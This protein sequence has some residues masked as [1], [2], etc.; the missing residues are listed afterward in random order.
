[1]DEVRIVRRRTYVWPVLI[2]VILL[3]LVLVYVVFFNR[4]PT[5][6][7]LGL[8]GVVPFSLPAAVWSA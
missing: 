7:P 6:Q 8:N 4:P 2:A 1:M 5:G 3:A